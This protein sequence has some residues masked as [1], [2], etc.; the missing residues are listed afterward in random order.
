MCLI[1]LESDRKV[2]KDMLKKWMPKRI[3]IQLIILLAVHCASYY[4]AKYIINGGDYYYIGSALDSRIPLLP[5]T[6][7]FY[8]GCFFFWIVYYTLIL[9]TEPDGTCRFFRAEILGKVIC[10]LFYVLL[11]TTMIRPVVTETG[12]FPNVIRM[13]YSID[14][15]DALFPSMHCFVSWMCVVGLRGKPEIPRKHRIIAVIAALLVFMATLTTKQHVIVDV[16]SGV[17]LAELVY[18]ISG[19]LPNSKSDSKHFSLRRINHEC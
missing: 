5:W 12:F 2:M 19:L 13:M 7:I 18:F 14:T 17:L 11:P 6:V 8:Y 15:P 4:G 3:I 10:F 9:N 16:I 1:N